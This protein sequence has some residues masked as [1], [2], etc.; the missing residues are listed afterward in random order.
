MGVGSVVVCGA[1]VCFVM[2][3]DVLSVSMRGENLFVLLFVSCSGE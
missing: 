2:V 3:I 1:G